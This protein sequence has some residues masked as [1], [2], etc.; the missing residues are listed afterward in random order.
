M[1]VGSADRGDWKKTTLQAPPNRERDVFS[2]STRFVIVA[3]TSNDLLGD[4]DSAK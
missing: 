1:W 3:I 4:L 2:S